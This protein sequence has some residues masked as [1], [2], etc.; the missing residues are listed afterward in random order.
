VR[1]RRI[2]PPG[3]DEDRDEYPPALAQENDDPAPGIPERRYGDRGLPDLRYVDDTEN[4]AA[5]SAMGHQLRPFC[6]GQAFRIRLRWPARRE[7]L[8]GPGLRLAESQGVMAT[9]PSGAGLA[10]ANSP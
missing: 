4:Q 6:D 1:R 10:T 8:G 2:F 5:G 3:A 7:G 9:W